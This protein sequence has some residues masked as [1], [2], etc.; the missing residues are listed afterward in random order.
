VSEKSYLQ[1]KLDSILSTLLYNL[2][3][4]KQ[5][6]NTE[7]TLVSLADLGWLSDLPEPTQNKII[8]PLIIFSLLI[9]SHSKRKSTFS[10]T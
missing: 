10:L 8:L 4:C 6:N 5:K 3:Q 1:G 9:S 7:H 2:V